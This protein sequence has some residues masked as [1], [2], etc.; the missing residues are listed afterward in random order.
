MKFLCRVE[1]ELLIS[2]AKETK[3][4]ITPELIEQLSYSSTNP[5][6]KT[7]IFRIALLDFKVKGFVKYKK[8]LAEEELKLIIAKLKERGLE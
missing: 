4:G 7:R 8:N 3:L 1:Y 2:M 5:M 6:F